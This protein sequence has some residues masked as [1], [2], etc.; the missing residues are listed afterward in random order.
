MTES[1]AAV[2]YDGNSKPLSIVDGVAIPA[3][4]PSLIISGRDAQDYAHNLVTDG[5]GVLKVS[6][7][8]PQPPPGTTPFSLAVAEVDL[9]ISAPP[10]YHDQESAVIGSGLV[11]YLQTFASGAA[12]DPNER[13]SR[14]DIL[15]REGVGPTDH[16]VTRM[17][18]GGQSL[19]F[20]L[21]DVK[22]A[23]DGTSLTGDG[24]T[25]KVVIRRYRLSNAASEVD[26][27]VRG[28]MK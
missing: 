20:T 12:G 28:Y 11:L 23:R 2:L 26:A 21:P 8:P 22:A 17:Y 18:I 7:Q 13:G 25:T 6:N 24:S 1:R 3:S 5:E 27:E 9:E 16:V 19:S 4:T 10:A 15:W 14:V